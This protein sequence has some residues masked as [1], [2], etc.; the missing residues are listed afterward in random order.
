MHTHKHVFF[1]YI[2]MYACIYRHIIYMYVCKYNYYSAYI[3]ACVLYKSTFTY[4]ILALLKYQADKEQKTIFFSFHSSRGEIKNL[5]AESKQP[6]CL[7]PEKNNS[8]KKEKTQ[9]QHQQNL[10]K[11]YTHKQSLIHCTSENFKENF[12]S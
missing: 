7:P 3:Y 1:I 2:C 12:S 6:S 9:Q 4:V 5:F 10:S 8:N 11:S